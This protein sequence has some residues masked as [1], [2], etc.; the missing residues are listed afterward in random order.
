MNGHGVVY[1]YLNGIYNR[2]RTCVG[3]MVP[4]TIHGET[5][6]THADCYSI[7]AGN[8]GTG[9]CTTVRDGTVQAFVCLLDRRVSD[10]VKV[11]FSYCGV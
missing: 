6:T 9:L 10:T 1:G 11:V 2:A 3:G 4:T 7:L 8:Y 5:N